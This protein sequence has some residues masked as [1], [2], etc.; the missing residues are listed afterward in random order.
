[1]DSIYSPEFNAN[2]S[3]EP[4]PNPSAP[5]GPQGTPPAFNP[6]DPSGSTNQSAG[7]QAGGAGDSP[8]PTTP[9]GPVWPDG[10]PNTAYWFHFFKGD[11]QCSPP[12][13]APP[14]VNWK[15]ANAAAGTVNTMAPPEPGGW[16][17]RV[18]QIPCDP[19]TQG[20]WAK[21]Y[22]WVYMYAT[23]GGEQSNNWEYCGSGPEV[24]FSKLPPNLGFMQ[25]NF[26]H[27]Y[28]KLVMWPMEQQTIRSMQSFQQQSQARMKQYQAEADS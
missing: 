18:I 9:S 3:K 1:M 28:W 4:T 6:Y 7:A 14:D 15:P 11:K 8:T 22:K 17:T 13:G 25:K 21:Y 26:P 2:N 23:K 19:A 16:T 27:E 5:Q 12:Q 20:P 10:R 24:D